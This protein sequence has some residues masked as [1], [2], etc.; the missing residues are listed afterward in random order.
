MERLLA[1]RQRSYTHS[2]SGLAMR[3]VIIFGGPIFFAATVLAASPPCLV[4]TLGAETTNIS[5]RLREAKKIPEFVAGALVRTV[6][7]L[8]PAARAGLQPGDVIQAVGGDLVQNVCGLHSAI[9]RHGCGEVRL[10]VRRDTATID[11]D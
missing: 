8:S 7:P 4:P 3:S 5:D 9:E 2:F 11:I 1:T 10:A 6:Q